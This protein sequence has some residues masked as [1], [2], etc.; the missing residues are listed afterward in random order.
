M[1]SFLTNGE[2]EAQSCQLPCLSPCCEE[3]SVEFKPGGECRCLHAHCVPGPCFLNDCPSGTQCPR[4][5]GD[6]AKACLTGQ[7]SEGQIRL[8]SMLSTVSR[9]RAGN[10]PLPALE[11]GKDGAFPIPLPHPKARARPSGSQQL[12]HLPAAAGGRAL[13]PGP[14]PAPTQRVIYVVEAK[15]HWRWG[16]ET[17]VRTARRHLGRGDSLP[18]DPGARAAEWGHNH[19]LPGAR[20]S[21]V[22]PSGPLCLGSCCA[23][24]SGSNGRAG[25]DSQ[26]AAGWV[27]RGC[28]VFRAWV[29]EH[30]PTPTS[31]HTHTHTHPRHHAAGS[32]TGFR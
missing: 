22:R 11:P 9:T 30:T 12:F 27:P 32:L 20:R 14:P 1:V 10:Q 16:L 29:G 19:R 31:V 15:G 24:T 4:P 18:C 26:M 21:L 23:P 7:G 3:E 13:L 2:T 5:W 17:G 28:T 25:G 6:F 8:G